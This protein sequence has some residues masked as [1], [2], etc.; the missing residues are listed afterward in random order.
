MV[1]KVE[2]VLAVSLNMEA[3]GPAP[4]ATVLEAAAEMQTPDRS[5][6]ARLKANKKTAF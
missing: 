3:T 2:K 5:L 6:Q 4:Q 1:E